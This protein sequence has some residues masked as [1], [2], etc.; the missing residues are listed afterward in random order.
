[1]ASPT[2]IQ[3][4]LLH[5]PGSSQRKR[6]AN[7]FALKPEYAPIDSRSLAD[8]LDQIH[9]FSRLIK[10]PEFKQDNDQNTHIEVSN[11]LL[12]FEN[13]LPFRLA[14]FNKINFPLLKE[15]LEKIIENF[16][17]DPTPK[18]LK[19]LLEFGFF[20]LITPL[21]QLQKLVLRYNF[22]LNPFLE[23]IINESFGSYLLRYILLS[24]T[25]GK[26]FCLEKPNFMEFSRAPWSLP[27]ED[28]FS[29]NETIQEAS[30]GNKGAIFWLSEQLKNLFN[31][32]VVILQQIAHEI[33]S[34]LESSLEALKKQHE[35]HLGLLFAFI[36]LFKHFQGDLNNL[37]QKHLDFFYKQ[38]L[39]IKPKGLV[40]DKTHLVFEIAKHLDSYLISK[41]TT[42]KDG[43]DANN[44]DIIFKLDDEIVIDKA[45]IVDLKT[46]Y[47]NHVNGRLEGDSSTRSFVEGVYIAPVANSA[48]GKGEKFREEQSKNWPAMGAKFSKFIAPGNEK[49]DTHPLGR[50]GF[51]LAS[52]VLW[53]NEGKRKITIEIAC[54]DGGNKDMFKDCFNQNLLIQNDPDKIQ[55]FK[56]KD[57]EFYQISE[58]TINKIENLFSAEAKAFLESMLKKN[59]PFLVKNKDEIIK[60]KVPILSEFEI[61][62][63]ED[64][65]EEKPIGFILYEMPFS[66]MIHYFNQLLIQ[67]KPYPIGYDVEAFL[68]QEDPVSCK[69]MLKKGSFAYEKIKEILGKDS[70]KN[71]FFSLQFSGEEGWFTPKD[72]VKLINLK[73]DVNP[74]KL[75]F[76]VELASDEPSVS[77]Y[78]AEVIKENFRLEHPFPVVKI[79]LNTEVQLECGN[80]EYLENEN[81]KCCLKKRDKTEEL[82]IALYHFFR[83]LKIQDVNINVEVCGVKQLVVQ[84]EESLQDVNSPILPFGTRPKVGNEFYIGSKEVFCKNWKEVYLNI[85]WKDLPTKVEDNGD[86][87]NLVLAFDDLYEDYYAGTD[88]EDGER[89][90]SN[91]SFKLKAALLAGGRW[92]DKDNDNN[93]YER[94]LFTTKERADFCTS[95]LDSS[96]N[97]SLN[98]YG[99]VP[100]NFSVSYQQKKFDDEPL[101][102]LSV[103]SQSAF[104]KLSLAGVSF[105]HDRYAL[106]LSRHLMKL[107]KLIDPRDVPNL[108]TNVKVIDSLNLGVR[109]TLEKLKDLID[110]I[111]ENG[112]INLVNL[113][114]YIKEIKSTLILLKANIEGIKNINQLQNVNFRFL[115]K[116][117][118]EINNIIQRSNSS[119]PISFTKFKEDIIKLI[120]VIENNLVKQKSFIDEILKI[121]P[122]ESTIDKLGLPKEPYTPTIKS[123]FID[124]EACADK[125][126]IELVHLYPF[127]NSSKTESL[128]LNPTLLPTFTDEGSLFI[129]LENLRPGANLQLLFQFAEATADSEIGRAD[130]FW[131]YL[132]GNRW[133]PLRSGFEILSDE[134]HKMTRSGIVKIAV[135]SNISNTGNTIMPPSDE[136]HLYW[137]KVS[138]P[139]SSA[140][141]AEIIGIH[142]QAVSATFLPSEKNDPLRLSKVLEP[143]KI[144]KPI[145]PDF[146]IKKVEQPYE[147]FGGKLPE[148]EGYFHTRVSEQLRHKNRSVDAFD[149][150]HMVLE[151]FPQLFKCKCI[152]HTFGLSAHDYRR[153]LEVAPG[154]IILTVVPDLTKLKSGDMPEPKVPS[155]L[156]MDIKAF[157]Q[158]KV[159][160]FARIK[161]LNPRYEKIKVEV[162]VRLM[163]GRDQKFYTN[164][165]KTDLR[166]FLAPWHLGDADK[167]SFGQHLVYS[168]VIGFVENLEYIDFITDLKLFDQEGNEGKEIIPRTARS[169]LTGG[170]I[171]IHLDLKECGEATAGF[172]SGAQRGLNQRNEELFACGKPKPFLGKKNNKETIDENL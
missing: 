21:N 103:N 79:V 83:H 42:F 137:L 71:E 58:Q 16:E 105:Q 169:I 95:S 40:P 8:I 147:S 104:L 136:K 73:F 156:I 76:E 17:N 31:Q 29:T 144:S 41:N 50:T 36:H 23:K 161:V 11:W 53:L 33:P 80:D 5:H 155:S 111:K 26:Y 78:D 13:S 56:L 167:I 48:D 72:P 139:T 25:A 134:T 3:H 37:T 160:P 61:G 43:K 121:L 86:N 54:D 114:D 153:D 69:P 102:P 24:N 131:H 70:Q 125:N 129:G 4:P 141:V 60:S 49:P 148:E 7:A 164:Q 150:E 84:N 38:I 68:T 90:I 106:V 75:T 15:N 124:Y 85:L 140:A 14:G 158:K 51:V 64:L 20:E 10:F 28:I 116:N 74:I 19:F 45:K 2:K 44:E 122:D 100:E 63:L 57:K 66:S 52:P 168:N 55:S 128:D 165:L 152:S 159:S 149:F 132:S 77:F 130:I 101:S 143:S 9:Q 127:A 67:K 135:P 35:P 18:N 32:I 107:A 166:K 92:K 98:G 22:A 96:D 157:L 162:T 172:K 110:K 59:K 171:C 34:H 6:Q 119:D 151:E 138:T 47:L 133:Q 120:L 65:L 146:S 27:I 93:I 99:F 88:Y 154:F 94:S 108:V 89:E 170:E 12:F 115:Q 82:K 91:E 30:A 109:E 97:F 113:L 126:D 117:I 123:I 118:K 39:Q 46:L 112:E 163:K 62:L 1:M 142:T 87:G 145:Q 81:I